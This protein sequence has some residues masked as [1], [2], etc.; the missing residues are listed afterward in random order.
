EDDPAW[1][2][3]ASL[4]Q[5]DIDVNILQGKLGEH[6]AMRTPWVREAFEDAYA[7]ATA[8]AKRLDQGWEA[9]IVPGP[10]RAGKTGREIYDGS[11]WLLREE[12]NPPTAI[13]IFI[14]QVKSG[15]L[16]GAIEQIAVTDPRREFG[17]TIRL[18]RGGRSVEFLISPPSRELGFEG[19]ETRRLL[20]AARLP[21]DTTIARGI[22]AGLAIDYAKLPF[23]Q[24]EMQALARSMKQ[25]KIL[26]AL[27]RR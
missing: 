13:P 25:D 10:A 19:L 17:H 6:I 9:H 3:L 4:L 7:E 1:A 26:K 5:D 2:E 20:V 23:T 21:R 16:E 12:P 15:T 22:P 18:E 14:N 27:K 24:K 11:V 8:L